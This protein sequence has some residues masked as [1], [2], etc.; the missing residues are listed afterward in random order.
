MQYNV[1][2]T[3]DRV[4]TDI[5]KQFMPRKKKKGFKRDHETFTPV[6]VMEQIVILLGVVAFL[7]GFWYVVYRFAADLF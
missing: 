4:Y 3:D 6:Q 1:L 2:N 7:A 5:G